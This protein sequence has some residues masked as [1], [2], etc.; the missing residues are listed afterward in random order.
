MTT[1]LFANAQEHLKFKGIPIDGAI[2]TFVQKIKLQGYKEVGT[3]EGV[4]LLMGEFADDSEAFILI[5]ENDKGNVRSV[6][7][8]MEG[9]DSWS[10]LK[11]KYKKYKSALIEKYGK[12]D[13]TLE[14]FDDPYYEF[15]G[16]EISAF[17]NHKATYITNF[18]QVEGD[19]S[20]AIIPFKGTI[21]VSL[22]YD[23]AQNSREQERQDAEKLMNDI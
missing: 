3:V 15:D 2:E 8:M 17:K 18:A 16:Y 5:Y 6:V 23:D 11:G 7:V 21:T 1:C 19:I 22:M 20:V 9:G 10:L 12:P 14:K 13:K 4:S